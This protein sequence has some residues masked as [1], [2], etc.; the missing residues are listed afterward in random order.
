MMKTIALVLSC[1]L[2]LGGEGPYIEWQEDEPLQWEDFAGDADPGST[3]SAWAYSTIHMA[4][5]CRDHQF[6]FEAVARFHKA[7]SWRKKDGSA[8]LLAHE[9]LH[10][11]IAELY[12]RKL[13]R[14]FALMPDACALS[15]EEVR[16]YTGAFTEEWRACE[17]RYDAE[18]HHSRDYEAQQAWEHKVAGELRALQRYALP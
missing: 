8:A 17:A 18:T 3:M 5:H 9:Q 4:W 13:R 12:A 1:L 10:F 14:H 2:L 15:D 16:G 6:Q 11:D 7:E